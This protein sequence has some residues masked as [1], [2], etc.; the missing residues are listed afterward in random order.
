MK[1]SPVLQVPFLFTFLLPLSKQQCVPVSF[2]TATPTAI[3]R[4]VIKVVLAVFA[5]VKVSAI[6]QVAHRQSL[7]F[8]P[9]PLAQIAMIL[10]LS[11][12]RRWPRQV[13][14]CV[15]DANSPMVLLTNFSYVNQCWMKLETSPMSA[16]FFSWLSFASRSRIK[17]ISVHLKVIHLEPLQDINK[18]LSRQF[19]T[20]WDF[21]T[22][23][24]LTQ[25]WVQ[26]KTD[27]ILAQF[28]SQLGFC[29]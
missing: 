14:S 9:W 6:M 7:L 15:I 21:S 23:V 1:L 29:F 20:H 18:P 22:L 19:E 11:H 10:S 8:L 2:F 12:H 25:C 4:H 27:P 5:L 26:L 13:L 28:F 24:C 17:N 3:T 16:R